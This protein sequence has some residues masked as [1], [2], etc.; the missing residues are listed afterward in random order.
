VSEPSPR[1]VLYALVAAGFLAVVAILIVGAAI[2]GLV[3]PWWSMVMAAGLVLIGIWSG[4]NWRETAP[5]LLV[6]IGYLV[7]W[8]IGTLILAI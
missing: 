8:M 3:P 4:L 2:A 6:S 7:I 1:Q 5:V